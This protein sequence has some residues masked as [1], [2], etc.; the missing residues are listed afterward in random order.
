MQRYSRDILPVF[1]LLFL[2]DMF[3]V[4]RS[5]Q[6]NLFYLN[7]YENHYMEL[8]DNTAERLLGYILPS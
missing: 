1:C 5:S 7:S 4:L 3:N 6:Y 8:F 2:I